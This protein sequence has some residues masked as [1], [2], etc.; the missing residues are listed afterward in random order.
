MPPPQHLLASKIRGHVCRLCLSKLQAPKRQSLQWNL[1]NINTNAGPRRPKEAEGTLKSPARESQDPAAESLA[2]AEDLEDLQIFETMEEVIRERRRD[3]E[4]GPSRPGGVPRGAVRYFEETPDGVRTEIEDPLDDEAT[5]EALEKEILEDMTGDVEGFFESLHAQRAARAKSAEY[6]KLEDDIRK[7]FAN[8]NDLDLPKV[9][10][11]ERPLNPATDTPSTSPTSAQHSSATNIPEFSPEPELTSVS[12]LKN[13]TPQLPLSL[14]PEDDQFW[15]SELN[16]ALKAPVASNRGRRGKRVGRSF[17][18]H[19]ELSRYLQRVWRAFSMSRTAITAPGNL[20]PDDMRLV[21]NSLWGIFHAEGVHNLNRMARIKSLGDDMV[22]AGITLDPA[23]YLLYMEAIFIEDSQDRA[24]KMWED[25]ATEVYTPKDSTS[26]WEL[27][28]RMLA[29]NGQP[30]RAIEAARSYVDKNTD[31]TSFRIVLPVIQA[32]LKSRTAMSVK[33][34]WA[35][36]IRLRV[37]LGSRMTMDDYDGVIL[38]LLATDQADLALG[39]FKDMM[40]AGQDS[41]PNEDST[42]LYEAA[43]TGP[44]DLSSLS[45]TLEELEWED[46]Q[47]LSR[48]PPRWNN[49]FFFGKWIRKLISEKELVAAEQVFKLM[50]VRGIEPSPIQLNG[51]IGAWYRDGKA[52]SRAMADEMAWRMI[53]ARNKFVHL[54]TENKLESHIRMIPTKDK[55]SNRNIILT[56]P[57]TIETFCVLIEQYRRRQNPA[58]MSDL[59]KAFRMSAIPPN[60][61]FLNQLLLSN[62]RA[63]DHKSAVETYQAAIEKYQIPADSNT[64][65]LLWNLLKREVDP[66]RAFSKPDPSERFQK[67]RGLFADMLANFPTDSNAK[68]PRALYKLIIQS[69]SLAQDRPGTA[70]AMR[71]LAMRFAIYPEPE[72]ARAVV[73]QLAR[74]GLVDEAGREPRRLDLDS[75]ISRRRIA[76]VTKILQGFKDRRVEA[77]RQRGI[78][79][80]Q[81]EGKARLEEPMMLL[82]DLLKFVDQR[83]VDGNGSAAE[84]SMEA[85]K[86]MGVPGCVVW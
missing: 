48:L 3:A 77:L 12:T 18:Q 79:F 86:A 64:Y 36:Y 11:A 21:L 68:F 24:I 51:L 41:A 54:R 39:V 62:M 16:N 10:E 15:I 25:V 2:E 50:G 67:C 20:A 72:T 70:V 74:L 55:P 6:P 33:R 65:E 1:R 4:H 46:A 56:P 22:K 81:L 52:H 69:F 44:K 42:M 30:E 40:L 9:F 34:A 23:Q 13:G 57:A 37:S 75:S 43:T 73:L 53:R 71:A 7:E 27:G 61:A 63:H 28:T 19:E 47:S 14:F 76:E 49:K 8:P 38:P 59:M 80:D 82:S 85:A 78:E 5:L 58:S 84:R 29:L 17:S 26:Y 66:I 31:P 32:Y 35:L 83:V 60:T 45:I